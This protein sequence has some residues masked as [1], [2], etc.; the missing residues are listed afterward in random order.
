MRF[1]VEKRKNIRYNPNIDS[2]DSV[3]VSQARAAARAVVL[4][5]DPP[6]SDKSDDGKQ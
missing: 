1:D 3:P 4:T 5:V 6:I 2:E